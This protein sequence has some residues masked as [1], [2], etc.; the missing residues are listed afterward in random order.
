MGI[1]DRLFKRAYRQVPQNN[2]QDDR[3]DLSSWQEEEHT[4]GSKECA[5]CG[6]VVPTELVQCPKCGKGVFETEKSSSCC[7]PAHSRMTK[8]VLFEY[9]CPICRRNAAFAN[10]KPQRVEI[11]FWDKSQTREWKCLQCG[12]A[13]HISELAG[14]SLLWSGKNA[15]Y[16]LETCPKCLKPFSLYFACGGHDEQ[17]RCESCGFFSHE[18]WD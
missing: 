6:A 12:T 11:Q 18:E 2:E 13:W 10:A 16:R 3:G 4:V 17:A 1:L 14:G 8:K 5:I 7:V 9:G 15:L